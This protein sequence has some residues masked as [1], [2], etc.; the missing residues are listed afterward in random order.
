[1]PNT[2]AFGLT[3]PGDPDVAHMPDEFVELDKLMLSVKILAHA[4]VELGAARE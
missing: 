2:V 4:I 3:F 1:M